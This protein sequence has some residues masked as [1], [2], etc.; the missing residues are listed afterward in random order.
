M[1]PPL[2]LMYSK[3][4]LTI[5]NA[6]FKTHTLPFPKRSFVS[7]LKKFFLCLD[8]SSKSIKSA[9]IRYQDL[10]TNIFRTEIVV[11]IFSIS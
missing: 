10:P 9:K 3:F 4:V 11:T 2:C 1:D 8:Q 7:F 6:L 5:T